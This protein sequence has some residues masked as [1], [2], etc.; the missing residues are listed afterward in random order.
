[1]QRPQCGGS[2]DGD[3]ADG[4]EIR[5]IGHGA[6]QTGVDGTQFGPRARGA[7][8]DDGGAHGGSG[9]IGGGPLDDTRRIPTEY[10]SVVS[11]GDTVD[12]LAAVQ[13]CRRDAHQ[14]LVRRRFG[15]GRL[16]EA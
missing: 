12:D 16:A 10:G 5:T 8:G 7:Q 3:R 6:E 1:M 9:A 13:R 15:I 14:R 4:G 2:C 11:G